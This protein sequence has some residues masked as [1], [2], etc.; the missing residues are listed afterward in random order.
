MGIE[1][2]YLEWFMGFAAL[3]I[4]EVSNPIISL[5]YF[6]SIILGL[7]IMLISLDYNFLGL[8]Y[9]VVYVGAI[10]ILILFIIMLLNIKSDDYYILNDKDGIQV[11]ERNA[12]HIN[13]GGLILL[14]GVFYLL[15]I[16]GD[17]NTFLTSIFNDT[18]TSAH[19]YAEGS[20]LRW[21]QSLLDIDEIT[22]L[23]YVFYTEYGLLL[24]ILGFLLLLSMVGAIVLV[25]IKK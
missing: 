20:H 22:S 8:I 17:S 4:Y 25:S 23:G 24:I 19:S 7:A 13:I 1:L 16:Q 6:I 10:A 5:G 3:S 2:S 21:N 14:F 12:S 11:L 18:T 9:I 15:L